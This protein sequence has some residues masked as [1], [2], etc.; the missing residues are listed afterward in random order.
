MAVT[1]TLPPETAPPETAALPEAVLETATQGPAANPT[2]TEQD[3]VSQAAPT[4]E[5]RSATVITGTLTVY[6]DTDTGAK[7]L[8]VLQPGEAVQILCKTRGEAVKGHGRTRWYRIQYT[9]DV[10]GYV[11]AHGTL[12]GVTV[13]GVKT[14]CQ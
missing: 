13:R 2:T 4:L 1:P 8:G 11:Y 3:T 5:L 12:A 9:E 7:S 14:E 10:V 6:E